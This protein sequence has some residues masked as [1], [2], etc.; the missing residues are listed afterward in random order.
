[1][2]K[3]M[4]SERGGG[5]DKKNNNK[6]QKNKQKN[7]NTRNLYHVFINCKNAFDRVWHKALWTTMRKYNINAKKIR[8][9]E[10]RDDRT[11]SEVL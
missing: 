6:K 7:F 8:V 4:V 2:R 11:Q 3:N 9:I 5:A 1:M 10:N